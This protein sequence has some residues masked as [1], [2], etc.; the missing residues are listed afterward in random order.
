MY[1]VTLLDPVRI[2]ETAKKLYASC[3]RIRDD[4]C[5]LVAEK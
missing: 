2:E 5:A 1:Y 4:L 3:V